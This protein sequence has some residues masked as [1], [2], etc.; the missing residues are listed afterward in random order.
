MCREHTKHSLKPQKI[1]KSWTL[2][3]YIN[4]RTIYPTEQ[5]WRIHISRE[6][7]WYMAR[8]AQDVA[9][10]KPLWEGMHKPKQTDP[11]DNNRR[12]VFMTYTKT[13]KVQRWQLRKLTPYDQSCK[14]SKNLISLSCKIKKS[15]Q[16]NPR[17][18]QFK[19][20]TESNAN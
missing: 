18:I 16:K 20:D 13:I 2:W 1:I 3:K 12:K 5:Q 8:N 9:R 7:A 6:N 11:R 14:F 15:K 17:K 10:D 19:L 4:K